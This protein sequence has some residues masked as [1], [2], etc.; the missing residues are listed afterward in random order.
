M[1]TNLTLKGSIKPLKNGLNKMAKDI[2]SPTVYMKKASIELYKWVQRN[3]NSEGAL[4]GHGK[5]WKP[6]ALGGRL[7]KDGSID[8][9][10]MIL[11]DEGTLKSSFYS[12]SSKNLAGVA[13]ELEYSI[14][15]DQGIGVPQRR[16][17]PT[18]DEGWKIV[19]P[20]FRVALNKIAKYIPDR[21]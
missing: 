16:I 4:V 19:E 1:A 13:S 12:F 7:K 17:L 20:L 3:F 14:N 21:S 2:A 5:K 18:E 8:I 10:A 6:L 9:T 11:Q 15:H